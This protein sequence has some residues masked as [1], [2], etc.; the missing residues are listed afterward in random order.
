MGIEA[1]LQSQ[2]I[3]LTS[4]LAAKLDLS[5]G[6]LTGALSG[7]TLELSG[8]FD[9]YNIKTSATSYERGKFAWESNV[10]RIGTEQGIAG[11]SGRNVEI[12][13]GGTMA[14]QAATNGNVTVT[15]SFYVGNYIGNSSR[16]LMFS[17]AD[18]RWCLTSNNGVNDDF[19][20]LQFGGITSL[21]PAIKRSLTSLKFRLA[22]DS[23]DCDI[24]A[25]A[26]TFSGDV[27]LSTVNVVT[28]TTTGTKIG[29][30]STQKLGFWNATPIVQPSAVADATDA[31]S[32][33]T[34]LNALLSRLRSAGLIAT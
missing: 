1:L 8:R 16:A 32:A 20:L 12:V 4:A 28:D 27:T 6:T 18:K 17:P 15:G 31:A 34:Q 11:G 14:L 5:G 13:A 23:A 29:T 9:A 30:G 33:I 22:N 25:K 10:L 26:A 24:T 7:T 2:V 3:G 21:F 19:E